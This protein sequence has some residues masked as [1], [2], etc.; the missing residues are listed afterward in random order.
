VFRRDGTALSSIRVL[1]V[2]DV[3]V[4]RQGIRAVLQPAEDIEVVGEARD[5]EEAI[6]VV[7]LLEPDVVLM[8]EFLPKL[9]GAA[10]TAATR[11]DWPSIHVIVVSG[12]RDRT[13]IETMIRAGATGYLTGND[14]RGRFCDTIRAVA[15][16]QV[17]L[18]TEG[19]KHMTE[20]D[21]VKLLTEREL[22]VLELVGK[23][24]TNKE[25]ARALIIS[26]KTVKTHVSH[27]I[28]KL[29]VKT[30]TQAALLEQQT[31]WAAARAAWSRPP[32]LDV[33]A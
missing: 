15:A 32:D 4:V 27:I 8:D 17:G 25:I 33:T 22:D 12:A 6:R 10:A 26:D 31:H 11:Q 9:N 21:P 18:A 29:G 3:D 5:G 19:G 13:S 7:R 2:D 23:G 16:G 28:A 30:R 1:I 14:T 20:G 24:L